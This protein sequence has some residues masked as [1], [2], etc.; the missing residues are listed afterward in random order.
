[1]D[2]LTITLT[3]CPSRKCL[4]CFMK[5]KI[6]LMSEASNVLALENISFWKFMNKYTV[7]SKAVQT[8]RKPQTND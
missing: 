2:Q 3:G 7:A 1:M 6:A 4:S 5:C 8:E